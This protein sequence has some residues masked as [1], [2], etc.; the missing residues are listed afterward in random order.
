MIQVSSF[1]IPF[2]LSSSLN[3]QVLS[4][5]YNNSDREVSLSVNETI[6]SNFKQLNFKE[7]RIIGDQS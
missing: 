2:N 4:S 6:K 7:T 5:Y 1:P 3:T